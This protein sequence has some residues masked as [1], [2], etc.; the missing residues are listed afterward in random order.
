MKSKTLDLSLIVPFYNVGE[1]FYKCLKSIKIQKF[2]GNAEVIFINDCSK[3]NSLKIINKIKLKNKKIFSLKKNEGPS[4]ARNLGIKKTLGKYIF[5]LDADDEIEPNTLNILFKAAK[6]GKFDIITADKKWIE[7]NKNQR[8]NNFIFSNNRILNTKNIKNLMKNRFSDTT[9]TVGMFGLTGKLI[10]SSLI[11]KNKIFFVNSMRNF[12]DETFMW[13]VLGAS[14]KIFYI[15][16]QLYSHFVNAG[17][18]T[19]LSKG[20]EKNFSIQNFKKLKLHIAKGLLRKKFSKKKIKSISGKGFI[21]FI[22]ASLVSFTRS[23]LLKKISK[24]KGILLR[25]KMIKMILNDKNVAKEIKFYKPSK[26]ESPS[27]P[28]SIQNKLS[29]NLEQACDERAREI[30][31]MRRKGKA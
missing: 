9:S 16:K 5:F 24:K 27:I 18:S 4:K 13:S 15:K 8:K 19:G 12:E 22:I 29:F 21:Y 26:T 31:K 14:K 1:N 30:I 20:Y 7:R 28:L 11:K 2:K 25:K 10:R 17:I 23:I 6:K 3:D